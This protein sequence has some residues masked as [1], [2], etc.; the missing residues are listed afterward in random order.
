MPATLPVNEIYLDS[1]QLHRL[2]QAFR[3]WTEASPRRDVVLSR[4]RIL[5][6]FLLI[7]YT[8]AKLN[9]ILSLNPFEDID[10]KEHTIRLQGTD[11]DPETRRELQISGDLTRELRRALDD[12]EF[13][14]SL[15]N[16]FNID[17]AFVR[18]K[19][20]ERA[21][22]CGFDKRLGSPEML[23]KARAVELMRGNLPLPAVQMMLG[24][25]TVHQTASRV[26]FSPEELQEVTRLFM[27]RESDRRT[28]ARNAF[29]GKITAIEPGD[30][31]ARVELATVDGHAVTT[32]ITNNSRERMAL[33]V[34][35]LATAEI[36]A[37]YV[38]L[39]RGDRPRSS[40]DN[41]FEGTVVR[42]SRGR[43]STEYVVRI[44][45]AAELCSIV[46]AES[47]ARLDLKQGDPV[48][49]LFNCFAVIL[50]I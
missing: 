21:E 9:E 33:A 3:Q 35:T 25:S 20:Y 44:S 8:G 18:R 36:K 50:H 2:E 49:A 14:D 1:M 38:L 27:N 48:W 13:A 34:G 31:Q 37:P 30:V 10:T 12:P 6:I 19:F 17:P 32:L 39:Q 5:I 11:G 7:R 42:I 46:S 15:H 22:E 47:A 16:H 45:E 28:S 24:Q 29:Y 41:A 43:V 23:R 26:P 40:A 4:R